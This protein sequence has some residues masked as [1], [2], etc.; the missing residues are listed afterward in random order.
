MKNFSLD[1]CE[2]LINA[3]VNEFGGEIIQ[4]SEGILGL[5]Y[6][7]LHGAKGKK[8]IVINEYYIN[9]WNSGHNVRMYNTTPKKYKKIIDLI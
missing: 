8:T 4:I 1:Y 5:G 7:L 2:N 3:Y 9:S 6:L